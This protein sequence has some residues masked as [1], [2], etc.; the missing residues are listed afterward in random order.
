MLLLFFWM[1]FRSNPESM[2][3]FSHRSKKEYYFFR[4]KI[5]LNMRWQRPAFVSPVGHTVPRTLPYVHGWRTDI[6]ETT[7]KIQI[8]RCLMGDNNASLFTLHASTQDEDWNLNIQVCRLISDTAANGPEL[9]SM[10]IVPSGG[11]NNSVDSTLSVQKKPV[12][13]RSVHMR[14][15]QI[16]LHSLS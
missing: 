13:E 2:L 10:M 9:L 14:I 11:Q 7:T 12:R 16:Y 1:E 8:Q 15:E 4:T 5:Y 3:F 6:T